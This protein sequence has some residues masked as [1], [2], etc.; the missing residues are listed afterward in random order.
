MADCEKFTLKPEEFSSVHFRVIKFIEE[1]GGELESKKLKEIFKL[2]IKR[3]Y[4]E[5]SDISYYIGFISGYCD[6]KNINS[7]KENAI[8]D[9]LLNKER[10]L[11]KG[12]IRILE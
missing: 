6:N 11:M 2:K 7:V 9:L 1:T 12:D 10:D 4:F 5:S 8:I 3:G